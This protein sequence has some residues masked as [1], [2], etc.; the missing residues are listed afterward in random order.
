ME[1]E[2]QLS[3]VKSVGNGAT[4]VVDATHAGEIVLHL[5]LRLAQVLAMTVLMQAFDVLQ[6]GPGLGIEACG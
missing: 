1:T 4:R 5:L 3:L 2:Y 6:L